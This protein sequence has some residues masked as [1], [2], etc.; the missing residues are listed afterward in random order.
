MKLQSRNTKDFEEPP[1]I[2]VRSR[3]SRIL[4]Q[5]IIIKK[6]FRYIAFLAFLACFAIRPPMICWQEAFKQGVLG[7]H[8]QWLLQGKGKCR[9]NVGRSLVITP[10]G[11]L[12]YFSELHDTRFLKVDVLLPFQLGK[13]IIYMNIV[14]FYNLNSQ[15]T[16]QDN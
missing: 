8:S 3:Q 4:A 16:I 15:H 12:F 10:T 5:N 6:Y 7:I 14:Y 13:N 2:R 1:E 9:R 11:I